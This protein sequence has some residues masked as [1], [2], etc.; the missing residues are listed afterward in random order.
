MSFQ[1]V[2]ILMD[3]VSG[4]L[5]PGVSASHLGWHGCD[6]F[7]TFRIKNTPAISQVTMERLRFVL[8]QDQY[9]S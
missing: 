3:G 8:S 1:H 4:S 7:T 9:F 5:I 6:E 2:E